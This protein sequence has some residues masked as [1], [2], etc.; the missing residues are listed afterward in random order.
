MTANRLPP[1]PVRHANGEPLSD[2]PTRPLEDPTAY[3]EVPVYLVAMGCAEIPWARLRSYRQCRRRQLLDG[4]LYRPAIYHFNRKGYLLI[5]TPVGTLPP[6]PPFRRRR[7]R[8]IRMEALPAAIAQRPRTAS[9][10]FAVRRQV[11]AFCRVH[12]NPASL[13][14]ALN[15]CATWV[16]SSS[17]PTLCPLQFLYR[18]PPVP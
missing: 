15:A 5:A 10:G 4:R 11:Y 14:M 3:R 6:R 1:R 16:W 8:L 18:W 9:S 2:C 7:C 12:P 13:P 17:I